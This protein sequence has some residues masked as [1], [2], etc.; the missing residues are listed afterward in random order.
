MLG[1][2]LAVQPGTMM[3]L[4]ALLAAASMGA[5]A[6]LSL[7]PIDPLPAWTLEP[8]LPWQF[9]WVLAAGGVAPIVWLVVWLVGHRLRRSVRRWRAIAAVALR[10]TWVVPSRSAWRQP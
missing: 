4:P 10:A 9:A 7:M 5:Q 6:P 8:A 1:T 2:A 3:T